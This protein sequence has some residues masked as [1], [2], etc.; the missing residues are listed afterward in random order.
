MSDPTDPSRNPKRDFA[1][2]LTVLVALV[3]LAILIVSFAGVKNLVKRGYDVTVH[4]PRAQGLAAGST[5]YLAGIQIGTVSAVKADRLPD[6]T[7]GVR[8]VVRIEEQYDLPDTTR[9]E[10]NEQILG[11]VARL[12]FFADKPGKGMLRKD[13]VAEISGYRNNLA[14]ELANKIMG[15]GPDG[16]PLEGG[17]VGGMMQGVGELVRSLKK[18]TDLIGSNFEPVDAGKLARGE[19]DPNIHTLITRMNGLVA[20]TDEVVADPALRANLKET[21]LSA[22]SA[23]ANLDSSITSVRTTLTSLGEKIGTAV[24]STSGDVKETLA[25]TRDT[26]GTMQEKYGK[27]ADQLN[28]TT[29][30]VNTLLE[31]VNKGEGTAGKLIHDPALYENLNDAAQRLDKAFEEVRQLVDKVKKEGVDIRLK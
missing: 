14:I 27:L 23:A 31:A 21:L 22:K 12:I 20:H 19:A 17:G 5:V 1:V 16:A 2:G 10:L 4:L 9:V 29:A 3:V 25:R 13:G 6:G 18:T 8:A 30:E 28:K 24:D 7:Y 26:L 15:Q 11:G